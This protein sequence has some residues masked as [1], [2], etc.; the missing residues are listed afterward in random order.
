[1]GYIYKN[2]ELW[3][4]WQ[5]LEGATK[6][7]D[8]GAVYRMVNFG[9]KLH[10]H[11]VGSRNIGNIPVKGSGMHCMPSYN[12]ILK[13]GEVCQIRWSPTVVIADKDG[14]PKWSDVGIIF[15]DGQYVV[16]NDKALYWFMENH[17]LN[18]DNKA[19]CR[20]KMF[21]K[22]DE[23]KDAQTRRN[24]NRKEAEVLYKLANEWTDEE[25]KSMYEAHFKRGSGNADHA[26]NE[27]K[28]PAL[29][30]PDAMLKLYNS[31]VRSIKNT[32]RRAQDKKIIAFEETKRFWYWVKE[33]QETIDPKDIITKVAK[34]LDPI[35]DL[36]K[37]VQ[38]HDDGATIQA[39]IE[40]SLE[41]LKKAA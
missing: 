35:D 18:R 38:N 19:L 16:K 2:N 39:I 36:L 5:T 26:R 33:K 10:P 8:G 14:T 12:H 4:D 1:M 32:L 37:F 17:I 6:I 27:L 24:Q 40:E 34:S 21:Y 41:G 15:T 29:K 3:N 9:T 25:V 28:T 22:V 30:D 13:S 7:P 31:D 23:V 20:K 11:Y